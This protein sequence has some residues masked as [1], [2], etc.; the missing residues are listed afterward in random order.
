MPKSDRHEHAVLLH[1]QIRGRPR[2]KT[3]AS[4]ISD[5]IDRISIDP[6]SIVES[7]ALFELSNNFADSDSVVS[8]WESKG[9]NYVSILDED[10]PTTLRN[11]HDAPPFIFYRGDLSI[12]SL[13]GVSV[14]GTREISPDGADM[15]L[16]AVRILKQLGLPVIS[17]LARGIDQAAHT[18]ALRFGAKPIGVIPTSITGPYTPATTRDLHESVAHEGL[19]ISQFEP[20][21]LVNKSNF[22]RRNATMSG[23][24]V[25]SIIIEAS[26]NSGTRSQANDAI[27]HGRPVVFT[28]HI[29]RTTKWASD[30]ADAS[31]PNIFVAGNEDEMYDAIKTALL[32][33]NPSHSSKCGQV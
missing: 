33:E 16:L 3:I 30:L 1:S 2:G 31:L 19:L 7:E 25:A 26:E 14:V 5:C 9:I 21:S 27:R 4:V 20:G 10:Y 13:N 8:S 24:G 17:G 12:S 29:V 23:L 6:S 28:R 18:A 11:V 32:I 15:T 22:L